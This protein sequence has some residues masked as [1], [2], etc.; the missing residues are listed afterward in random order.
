VAVPLFVCLA[1]CS[2]SVLAQNLYQAL[3]PGLRAW[4]AG[5]VPGTG[6]PQ[7]PQEMLQYWGV[8][9]RQHQ[10][11]AATQELCAG[12]DA[13]FVM[14]PEYA[15]QLFSTHGAALAEKTYLFADPFIMPRSF[16][17]GEYMVSDP[18]FDL[19]PLLEVI[20]DYEWFRDRVRQ[21]RSVLSGADRARLVPAVNYLHLWSEFAPSH[22]GNR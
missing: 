19:R 9:V 11:R 6:I 20:R 18:A 14:D 7:R 22:S 10:P 16:D 2:R 21:I 12:A 5:L 4:S 13:I 17:H 15:R 1:N 3:E 8:E